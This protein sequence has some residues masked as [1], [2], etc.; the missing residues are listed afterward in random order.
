MQQ[1]R[2]RYLVKVDVEE[3]LAESREVVDHCTLV[4]DLLGMSCRQAEM[5]AD[6]ETNASEETVPSI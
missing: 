4:D 3:L 1:S 5:H 2:Y 6:S